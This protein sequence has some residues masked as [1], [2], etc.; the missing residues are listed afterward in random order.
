MVNWAA[1]WLFRI[2]LQYAPIFVHC[3][4]KRLFWDLDM[5]A[6]CSIQRH[7]PLH[8]NTQHRT[9]Q[10][11]LL[12]AYEGPLH[13]VMQQTA[14]DCNRLQ[15]TATDCNRLQQTATDCTAHSATQLLLT[16]HVSH[17]FSV[18]IHNVDLRMQQHAWLHVCVR[19]KERSSV[20]LCVY[21]Y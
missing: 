8:R 2:Y 9:A 17:T 19:A 16:C 3:H 6:P 21:A 13:E 11:S 12:S 20:S 18:I 5:S 15:Q 14:T 4:P 7:T 10:L 1:S